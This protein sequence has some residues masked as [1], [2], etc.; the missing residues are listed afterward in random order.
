MMR[1]KLLAL[2][3]ALAMVMSTAVFIHAEDGTDD[4]QAPA[5]TTGEQTDETAPAADEQAE[6]PAVKADQVIKVDAEKKMVAGRAAKLK[7]Q[8][9]KGG[10]LSFTSSD[11]KVVTVNKSGTLKAK[12]IGKATI[13]VKAA[14]TDK[15]NAAEATVSVT[16]VPKKVTVT[17]LVCRKKGKFTIKWKKLKGVDGFE[18]AFCKDKKFRKAPKVKTVKNGKAAS[19][20]NCK[21]GKKARFYVKVRT[22]KTVDGVKYYSDWSKA[23]AVKVK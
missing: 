15:F 13:T 4:G 6:A 2:I 23:K 18:V 1:R 19:L 14:E 20:K 7:V 11:S 9:K 12:G 17:S 22:Y 8:V 10:K 21:A 16:V 3:M 5:V